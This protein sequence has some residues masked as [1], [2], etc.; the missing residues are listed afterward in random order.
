MSRYERYERYEP[1]FR[2]RGSSYDDERYGPSV[3][4]R[5]QDLDEGY[6]AV[7][8]GDRGS[9]HANANDGRR[10]SHRETYREI[11]R[12]SPRESVREVHRESHRESHHDRRGASDSDYPRGSQMRREIEDSDSDEAPRSSFR[13]V[14]DSHRTPGHSNPVRGGRRQDRFQDDFEDDG[15]APRHQERHDMGERTSRRAILDDISDEDSDYEARYP[16]HAT[17]SHHASR[18]TRDHAR[19]VAPDYL[20]AEYDDLF[21]SQDGYRGGADYDGNLDFEEGYRGGRRAGRF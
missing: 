15:Y 9:G 14:Y 6:D 21:E 4:G 5:A 20:H 13:Y 1:S 7:S 2:G 12:D 18:D 19:G 11:H 3:R 8:D 16:R 17:G 10:E